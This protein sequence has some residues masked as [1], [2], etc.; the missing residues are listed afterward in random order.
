MSFTLGP[1]AV[2]SDEALLA[3]TSYETIGSACAEARE[4]CL[5]PTMNRWHGSQAADSFEGTERRDHASGADGD[6]ALTARE[7][8]EAD[9]SSDDLSCGAGRFDV[10]YADITDRVGGDCETVLYRDP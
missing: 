5:A 10:A 9:W 3:G 8:V 2:L 6:D 4:A 7:S 1:N